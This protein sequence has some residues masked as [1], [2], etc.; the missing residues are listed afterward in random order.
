[1]SFTPGEA[2]PW[3]RSPTAGTPN[4]AFSAAAGRYVLLAFSPQ[5]GAERELLSAQIGIHRARLDDQHCAA[6]VVL[7]DAASIAAAK[8][9]APGVRYFLDPQGELFRLYGLEDE[10]GERRS[11]CLLLDPTLRII[12]SGPLAQAPGIF[13]RLAALPSPEEHAGTP[14]HAPVLIAPRIFEPAVCQRLVA[15]YEAKGGEASGVMREIGGRTVPVLDDFKSRRDALIEDEAFRTELRGRI[16]KRLLPQ[17]ENAF[18]FRA[19]R[20]ERYIV[21]RYAADEGG[22][23]RPHRDNTTKGTAHRK[24]ACSINLNDDFEGGDL[25]F[26]EYG[27]RTYRPPLGGAVVFSC[28]LLHEATAVT[29]GERFAF[30][31]FFYDEHGARI[32][33]ENSQHIGEAAES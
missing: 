4:F 22:Y 14:L 13:Q 26:P 20:M 29:R 1:M 23:F 6:F 18:Q 21:A 19:T 3:F 25:R 17:I 32:R 9:Q 16:V 11:V 31:P 8:D 28:S 30:L 10:G 7:S 33:A 15:F 2:V 12:A 27:R 24:F 5:P